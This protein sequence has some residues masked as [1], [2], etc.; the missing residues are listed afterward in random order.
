MRHF[1]VLA[2]YIITYLGVATQ[3]T[4]AC[5]N[6]A[7]QY[8][9]RS[10]VSPPPLMRWTN[11][12]G[13]VWRYSELNKPNWLNSEQAQRLFFNAAKAWS[14]CG[15]PIQF[16]GDVQEKAGIPSAQN[17]VGWSDELP[18]KI[19]GLTYRKQASGN[20][21]GTSII[22]NKDNVDIQ[23]DPILLQKVVTHEFGH[24]L[25]LIHSKG[26]QDVM[27]SAAMCG[28]SKLPPPLSPTENDLLECRMR[29]SQ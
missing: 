10:N 19:R 9:S 11:S 3:T 29:Y 2:F 27:S 16:A 14:N 1:I 21:L 12:Q 28:K 18:P 17:I 13:F 25:G 20:I 26:C 15:V 24:A 7:E 22:I 23:Q 4:L 8:E 6:E 5:A